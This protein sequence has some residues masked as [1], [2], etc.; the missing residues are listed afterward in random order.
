MAEKSNAQFQL[1]IPEKDANALLAWLGKRPYE[2]VFQ[3]IP[4]IRQFIQPVKKERT[5]KKPREATNQTT[6]KV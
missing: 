3:I 5:P 1:V 4:F 2:D 6:L